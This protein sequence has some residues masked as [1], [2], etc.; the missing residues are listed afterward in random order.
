M[1]VKIHSSW[2]PSK[3]LPFFQLYI[4]TLQVLICITYIFFLK[5]PGCIIQLTFMA[6][7]VRV[8]QLPIPV[9]AQ[10]T[11]WVCGHSL[12]GIVGLNPASGMD[13]CFLWVLCVVQVQVPCAGSIPHPKNPTKCMCV[14]ECHNN[15]YTHNE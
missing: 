4:L 11:A 9:A 7:Y 5:V 12:A 1:F 15:L 10:S 2:M 3:M 14:T 13:V 6:F 8:W